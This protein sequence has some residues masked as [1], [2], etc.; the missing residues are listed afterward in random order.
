MRFLRGVGRLFDVPENAVLQSLHLRIVLL[1][2]HIRMSFLQRLDRFQQ[3]AAVLLHIN[4]RMIVDVLAII[5]GGALHLADCRIDL[6]DANVLAG[7]HLG[8]TGL[9]IEEPARRAQIGSL[10]DTTWL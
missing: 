3:S 8:I 4:V 9:V 1:A 10:V 5:D 2:I 7:I 6:A